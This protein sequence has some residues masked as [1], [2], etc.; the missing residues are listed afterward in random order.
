[1]RGPLAASVGR[2]AVREYRDSHK[3]IKRRE[4]PVNGLCGGFAFWYLPCPAGHGRKNSRLWAVEW[5]TGGGK[6]PGSI[7][8]RADALEGL[9]GMKK[10]APDCSKGGRWWYSRFFSRLPDNHDREQQDKQDNHAGV[11]SILQAGGSEKFNSP[12][13][14]PAICGRF[15][16]N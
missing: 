4:G 11:T 5:R 7:G 3:C 10:P 16:F 14:S 8:T 6:L 13:V 1:M 15:Q 9:E 12:F 2:F